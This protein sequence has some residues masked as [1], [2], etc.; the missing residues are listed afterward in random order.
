MSNKNI[1]HEVGIYITK[2]GRLA[3]L[4]ETKIEA[5][6]TVFVGHT[7]AN[8]K[9]GSGTKTLVWRSCGLCSTTQDEQDRIIKKA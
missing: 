3:F 9:A 2:G 7:L 1:V 5:G 8:T 4:T 6:E